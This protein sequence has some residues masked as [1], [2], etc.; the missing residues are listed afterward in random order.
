VN[1]LHYEFSNGGASIARSRAE[2]ANRKAKPAL[3]DK[4]SLYSWR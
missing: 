1:R 4:A 2:T 3:T